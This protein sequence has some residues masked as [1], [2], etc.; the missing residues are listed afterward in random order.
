MTRHLRSLVAFCLLL[1]LCRAAVDGHVHSQSGARHGG[2][3]ALLHLAPQP[4]VASHHCTGRFPHLHP[5]VDREASECFLCASQRKG[6]APVLEST[7]AVEPAAGCASFL[8]E[9]AGFEHALVLL[10]AGP[11]APPLG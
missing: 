10:S 8:D 2:L 6:G 11:R 7:S 3:S 4:V 5:S 9:P 1:V